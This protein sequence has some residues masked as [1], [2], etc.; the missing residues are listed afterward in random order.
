MPEM[1]LSAAMSEES[2]GTPA[3]RAMAAFLREAMEAG[4]VGFSTGL[5][6]VPGI[7]SR[8]EEVERLAAIAAEYDA[9]YSTHMRDEGTYILEAINEFLNVIRKTGLPLVEAYL[10]VNLAELIKMA[11]GIILLR[12]GIWVRNIV[13][14]EE[15]AAGSKGN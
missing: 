5:E 3:V 13:T 11:I 8:P 2:C 14:G 1:R 6:F 4:F 9:N 12:R 10:F 15:I 7:N